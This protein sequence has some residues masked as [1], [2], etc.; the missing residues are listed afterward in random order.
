M[1]NYAFHDQ[2]NDFA[3]VLNGLIPRA[4]GGRCTP[5]FE[6][7]AVGMPSWIAVA[8]FVRLHN[9]FKGVGLHA[10][11]YGR[12]VSALSALEDAVTAG[13]RPAVFR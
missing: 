12:D 9:N 3:N 7:R 10:D 2:L 1:L 6:R 11:Y 4:P 8:I 5:A 13:S